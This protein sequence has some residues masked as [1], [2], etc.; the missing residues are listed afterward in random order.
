MVARGL[1]QSLIV[2]FSRCLLALAVC[3]SFAA[4][5]KKPVTV[6]AIT[7]PGAFRRGVSP[8]WSPNGES[9]VY[10]KDGGLWIYDVAG[11]STRELFPLEPMTK[12]ATP[13][14]PAEGYPWV[15][16]HVREEPIQWGPSG[17]ELLVSTGGDIFVW[18]M[19]TGKWD[20][21]TATPVT[22]HD[23]KLS[24]DGKSVAFRR[25]HDLYVLDIATKKETRLTTGGSDTLR[26]GETDWV[27]PEE[28]ELST[29]YWWSPDSKSIAYLQFDIVREPKYPQVD[30][31]GARAI[32]E[33][34]RYPQAGEPN[35]TIHLGVIA[36]AGGPVRWMDVGETREE[37]L[38][39]RVYWTPDSA[40]L[41]V[42]RLNR[43]QN[44]LDLLDVDT[45]TGAPRI[46]L[47]ETDPNWI[48]LADDFRILK[49]G[50]EFLWSSERTGFRH[51]YLYNFEGKE[52]RQ[53]T[54]GDWEVRG[55]A[56]VDEAHKRVYYLSSEA[57]PTETQFYSI[58]L[59]GKGERRLSQ[60]PGTHRVS[61]SPDAKYYMD[62]FSN[63][64][65]P[66]QEVLYHADGSEYAVYQK[67]DEKIQQEY[68][69]L[70]T[71]IL[72]VKAADGKTELY[73]RLIKPA[74][75]DS[76][77]KYPAI[78]MVYGGP[79]AQSVVNA[80]DGLSWDQVLANKGFVIW[81][82]DNRGSLG[83][84]H[85]FE[86]VIY[87]NM[88]VTELADQKAGIRQLIAMG[89][90]DPSRIGIFGWSYGG[91]MT[92]NS[93]LYAPDT[94]KAGISGAPV[95]NFRN[96]DTIY[97][98]RYMGLPEND[99][100]GYKRTDL[101]LKASS[102][103]AH[104]LLLDNIQDDNV[105]FQNMLQ[106]VNALEKAGKHFQFLVYTQKTH[107]VTGPVRKQMLEGMTAFF[108]ANL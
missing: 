56:G 25:N 101:S 99:P 107:G 23:A 74:G 66:P 87:H 77:K 12:A 96:Y 47:T 5:Q 22:E 68:N 91:F 37:Y 67:P 55:V 30:L 48:N 45:S 13:V 76:S 49:K 32:L 102:L 7:Q 40:H 18:H 42:Q 57:S 44:R 2:M 29:A 17:K 58:G 85:A 94:F 104:L 64:D 27:Y 35:A 41:I 53:I 82:V 70:P 50:R 3:A 97:T 69:I 33:P 100:D 103:E 88:G 106:I 84:G 26:N 24:P 52:L 73:A 92:L 105:L 1:L 36:A 9:F 80:W 108:E 90:V 62:S 21:L 89:F 19:D 71:Q 75:F 63:L 8:I 59:D 11:K 14:P 98:E 10:R 34:E 72:T 39:A 78:V 54:N 38:I 61:M 46:V 93:L 28:L 15:N 31:R 20:Q 65:T 43:V 95:T 81:Q 16:R 60:A 51:L 79:G 86:S 4:A 83:R 6:D